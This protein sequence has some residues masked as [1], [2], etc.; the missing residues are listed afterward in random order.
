M[1]THMFVY[2]CALYACAYCLRLMIMSRV[3]EELARP[4][5]VAEE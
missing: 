1:H 2:V 4:T 3:H 5:E